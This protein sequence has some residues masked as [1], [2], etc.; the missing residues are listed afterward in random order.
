MRT[1]IQ[2]STLISAIISQ[3]SCTG[4]KH[5]LKGLRDRT[6]QVPA[7]LRKHKLQVQKETL[8]WKN[9]QWMI[10]KDTWCHFLAYAYAHGHTYTISQSATE[11]KLQWQSTGL[12][13]W[14]ALGALSIVITKT[15][16]RQRGDLVKHKRRFRWPWPYDTNQKSLQDK[17]WQ[18]RKDFSIKYRHGFTSLANITLLIF[19]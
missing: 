3:D 16:P 4:L 19:K 11:T 18:K 8:I 17:D 2:I 5:Q 13:A 9:K 6:S 12:A 15:F 1:R 14:G 7:Y 10:R